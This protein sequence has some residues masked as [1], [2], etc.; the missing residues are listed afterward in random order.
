MTTA[1]A[2]ELYPL[3][4]ATG[5]REAADTASNEARPNTA[6]ALTALAAAWSALI[7]PDGYDREV[8]GGAVMSASALL[9]TTESGD[10]IDYEL[11]VIL[12]DVARILGA[13]AQQLAEVPA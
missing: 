12:H 6:I 7:S 4:T 5:I 10:I 11:A 9:Q 2:P 8:L 13:R 1:P 3:M